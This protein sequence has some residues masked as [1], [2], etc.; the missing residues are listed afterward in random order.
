MKVLL[1]G[2]F[3]N[4]GMSTLEELVARGYS[5]RVF[6]VQTGQNRTRAQAFEDHPLVEIFWGDLRSREKVFEAIDETIDVVIHVAAIIPPLADRNPGLA[7]AV[8][9]G[10]TENI[11]AAMESREK[12]PRLIYTSSIA[13]YGDRVQTPFIQV[14]DAVAPND[15]DDYAKTKIE[16]EN[17]ITQSHVEWAI[18]RLTYIVSPDKLEMDPLMFHMPLETSIEICHTKD[19]GVALANAVVCD[20]IWGGIYHIAGGERCRTTYRE[21][22]RCMM[23][24]FG[25]GST[26][27]PEEAFSTGKFHC[28]FMDTTR[29][30]ALLKYQHHTLEDYY[31]EVRKVVGVRRWLMRPVSWAARL[32]LLNRSAYYRK[33]SRKPAV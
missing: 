23:D 10:G 24:I 22:I 26:C 16:A 21:Y 8:N 15:D 3:G 25:L 14:T 32:Y 6:D 18:F 5:V 31:T 30:Q 11:L 17:R 19:V 20:E 4:V 1:T 27:L 29:S 12:R 2:A 9:V 33:S 28:G 13:V 7:R